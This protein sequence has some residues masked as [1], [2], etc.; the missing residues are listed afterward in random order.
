MDRRSWL[1]ERRA[2]VELDY[3]KDGPTYD[4]GYDPVTPVHRRWVGRLVDTVP[5]G[6]WILDVP[7]GTGPYFGAV[8]AAGRNVVGADQSAG[9]LEAATAKYPAVRTEKIGLQEIA[10]NAEFDGVMCVDSM[11]HVPPEEWP[12]VL[13]NLRRALM[14]GGHLYL[15]VEETDPEHIEA[16]DAEARRAGTPAVFGEVTTPETGGYH[17]YPDRDRV[18]RWLAEGGFEP[19]GK[20]FEQLDGYGYHHRLVR[21]TGS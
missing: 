10:F 1:A 2:A 15:T 17:F 7:C 4:V 13:R 20:E 9:M 16:A 5:E 11:E 18:R 6:G 12:L 8:L 14:P 21:A 3:T 19:V